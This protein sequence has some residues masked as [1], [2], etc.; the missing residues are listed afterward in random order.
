[1]ALFFPSFERE[2]ELLAAY[3]A[4]DVRGSDLRAMRTQ[5]APASPA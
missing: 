1:V 5:A 4:E 3:Q 2:N